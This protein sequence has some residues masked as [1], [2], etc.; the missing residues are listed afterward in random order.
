[1]RLVPLCRRA[2]SRAGRRRKACLL[3]PVCVRVCV[4][5][6]APAPRKWRDNPARRYLSGGYI[7]SADWVALERGSLERG[8]LGEGFH[9]PV[10]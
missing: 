9:C 7:V 5:V 10:H 8:G 1:M 4:K 3:D 2:R 6:W